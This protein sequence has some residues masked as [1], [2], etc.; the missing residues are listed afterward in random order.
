MCFLLHLLILLQCFINTDAYTGRITGMFKIETPTGEPIENMGLRHYPY[1][2]NNIFLTNEAGKVN[3]TGFVPR[4]EFVIE[5]KMATRSVDDGP[6]LYQPLF[7]Y[8]IASSTDFYYTS[9]IGTRAQARATGAM[10]DVPYNSSNGYVVVG[11]DKMENPSQ[12]LE[13]TNLKP[14]VG[15]TCDL[16]GVEMGS[17]P[18]V[19]TPKIQMGSTVEPHGSSFVTYADVV[20]GKGEVM[21]TYSPPS[22]FRSRPGVC[23]VSPGFVESLGNTVSQP[24]QVFPDSITVVSYVCSA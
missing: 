17:S 6:S 21:V 5:G 2:D 18:F 15:A 14:A 8:G 12:G 4:Q 3:V 19:F 20:P 9:F 1:D 23:G 7:I 24:I 13:P 11:M 22:R 16:Q 10:I